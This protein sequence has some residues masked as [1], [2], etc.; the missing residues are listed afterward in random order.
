ML[1]GGRIEPLPAGLGAL[2]GA[3][4]L[5]PADKL[6][7][8]RALVGLMRLHARDWAGVSVQAWLDDA[9]RR[10][11]PRLVLA[12]VARAY[13]YSAALDLVS[14]EVYLDKL[15]RSLTHP[16]RYIDG[17]WQ[18]FV[19]GLR[20]VAEQAGARIVTGAHVEAVTLD[21]GR[22]CGLR[23]GDGRTV[24]AA[25]V[26]VA[27]APADATRLIDGAPG[28]AL[29]GV[30]AGCLPATVACLDVALRRL[31]NPAQPVV[32]DLDAPR[33]LTAQS[34]FSRVAPDGAGLVYTLQAAGSAPAQRPARRRARSGGPA[35]RGAAGL[36]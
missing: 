1:H 27:T 10:P 25:A 21:G 6:E 34:R 7:F 3:R 8:A 28:A 30:V 11:R 20:R 2:L 26:I 14:A 19:D 33:L 13:V 15:Q 5:S 22:A 36:A 35:R 4:L 16:I 29:R 31:P 24:P 12:G 18:T 23:L 9:I 32:Q 17:G